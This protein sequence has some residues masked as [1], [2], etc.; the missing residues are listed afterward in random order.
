MVKGLIL[1]L[2]LLS[3][4]F[5]VEILSDS[6]RTN[7]KG[8]VV[9]EGNVRIDQRD[10]IIEADRV[11]YNPETK[12]V[13]AHGKVYI[14]KKDGTL[15]V[16]GSFAYLDMRTGRGYFLDA[17]GRFRRFYFSAKRIDRLGE[18]VFSFQD[19]DVTTCPPDDK[20]MKVCFKRAKFTGKYVVS[21]V[22][23]LR[24]FSLP[25]LFSPF[26]AFPVGER[27]SGLLPPVIGSNTYNDIIYIQPVYWAISE[28]KDAT[29]TLDLRNRQASGIWIEYRQAFYPGE[30]LYARVSYYREPVPPGEWWEGR[31]P[32]TFKR[33]RYRLEL[34]TRRG[35]WDLSLDVPSDP[36]FFEDVY[37]SQKLRTLPY[38]VNLLTYRRSEEEYLLFLNMRVFYDL[39]SNN[40]R[41]TL[42]LLPEFTFYS[43]P[44]KVW[45]GFVNLTS[46]FTNF[47]REEGLRTK[48]LIFLPEYEMFTSPLGIRN[49]TRVRLITNLYFTEGETGYDDAVLSFLFEDRVHTFKEV[50]LGGFKLT[51]TFELVYTFSP[52][53]FNNPQLDSFDRVVRENN[54]KAR[55]SSS[56]SFGERSVA[57]IFLESG[58]NLL[59]SYRFPTDSRLIEKPLLPVRVILSLRPFSWGS[60][61][62]DIVYDPNLNM[63]ARSV[64]SLNLKARKVSF[65]ISYLVSRN[66]LNRRISD[67]YILRGGLNV[68]GLTFNAATTYDNIRKKELYRS[69]S[70][71]YR[72]ACWSFRVSFRR[73]F[74]ADKREY[75]REIFL[76]FNLFN[77]KEFTLP[78]RRR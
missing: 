34:S 54:L 23:T 68:K 76:V 64:S 62:E 43:K 50:T 59:R 35:G 19:G 17:E 18:S 41:R 63:L 39:T 10:Y 33:N 70:L 9:A 24:F 52:E 16:R 36:Y 56:V 29:L 42:N 27:R 14:R 60:L 21:F 51:N 2:F 4:S 30:D 38:T 6:L 37:L 58:Y 67:Q 72:G 11:R 78:L 57:S 44:K 40:N 8:E 74:Y 20:E 45:K 26:V 13:F 66:S 75:F 77:L 61:T 32:E 73:T 47:Y 53:N 69:V 31:S 46:S 5:P 22:N 65:S 7:E 48:R 55:I 1:A 49:Y 71:G 28:D 15:E 25:V 12:E 3:V